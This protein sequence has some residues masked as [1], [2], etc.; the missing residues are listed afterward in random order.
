MIFFFALTAI[1]ISEIVSSQESKCKPQISNLCI[2][3]DEKIVFLKDIDNLNTEILTVELNNY[4]KKHSYLNPKAIFK[5][6]DA[7]QSYLIF[8]E[9]NIEKEEEFLSISRKSLIGEEIDH[10][11]FSKINSS[12]KIHE[13]YPRPNFK[14]N[15]LPES[16][17][18]LLLATIYHLSHIESSPHKPF[19]QAI[20]P[21][22]FPDHPVYTWTDPILNLLPEEQQ[23]QLNKTRRK[24][25][26]SYEF[27]VKKIRKV[28]REDMIHSFFNG[29]FISQ[30]D[31][32]FV[33][34][35]VKSNSLLNIEAP[36]RDV[37]LPLSFLSYPTFV[38]QCVESPK[39]KIQDKTA[40]FHSYDMALAGSEI[41]TCPFPAPSFHFFLDR[42]T[43]LE[44]N[45][46]DCV[47]LKLFE[48][49]DSTIWGYPGKLLYKNSPTFIK[50][51]KRYF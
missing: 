11:E 25:N 49:K 2:P 50:I 22:G 3:V 35:L 13:Y 28:W 40:V 12:L 5:W 21:K 41:L 43:P 7:T 30:I 8:A 37:F 48:K 10:S 42:G 17:F 47:H 9:E 24:L 51:S 45:E 38:E 15:I 36:F 27:F 16:F 31:Y 20:L 6:S 1:V 14:G 18:K 46:A 33:S 4:F 23:Y 19:L 29:R 32:L 39:F 34:L 26:E 44:G